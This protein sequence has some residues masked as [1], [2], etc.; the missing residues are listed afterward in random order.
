MNRLNVQ[1]MSTIFFFLTV[2][3][4]TKAL[5]DVGDVNGF[6]TQSVTLYDIGIM[7]VRKEAVVDGRKEI[8]LSVPSAHLDDVL[9]SLLVTTADKAQIT[10]IDYPT[11][12]NIAQAVAAG[13]IGQSLTDDAG[14]PAFPANFSE[15]MKLYVGVKVTLLLSEGRPRG[16]DGTV[17]GVVA[18]DGGYSLA[19]I[20]MTDDEQKKMVLANPE[21]LCVVLLTEGGALLKVPL[22][23]VEGVKLQRGGEAVALQD[24]AK[25]LGKSNGFEEK[26]IAIRLAPG[27]NGR[28]AAEYVQQSPT[29]RMWYR[30]IQKA[31]GMYLEGW[32]QVHN[33]TAE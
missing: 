19:G 24:L 29:W 16:L 1:V 25:E 17:M 12:K 10:G 20:D 9:D 28:M 15:T 30:L 26:R 27:A 3:V 23:R 22:N 8:L 2:A 7:Q 4:A 6:K 31:D 18:D 13:S 11:V 21:R 5:G 14:D 32:A 33:D